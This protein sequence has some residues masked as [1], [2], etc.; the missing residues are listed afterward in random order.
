[1]EIEFEINNYSQIWSLLSQLSSLTATHIALV[2]V[3]INLV[4]GNIVHVIP[5]L[6][7]PSTKGQLML[8]LYLWPAPMIFVMI[9]HRKPR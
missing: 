4:M 8:C 2:D 9:V 1:M 3:P 7:S 6:T 5:S